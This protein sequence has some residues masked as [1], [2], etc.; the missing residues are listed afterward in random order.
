MVEDL[1]DEIDNAAKH[2]KDEIP[3]KVKKIRNEV[4]EEITGKKLVRILLLELRIY[5]ARNPHTPISLISL[6]ISFSRMISRI[7]NVP[8]RRREKN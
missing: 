2:V 5:S 3:M 7:R 6:A 4:V 8:R 1:K